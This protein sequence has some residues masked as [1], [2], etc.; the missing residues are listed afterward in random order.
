MWVSTL[1]GMTILESVQVRLVRRRVLDC[2]YP[3]VFDLFLL[4]ESKQK[5][6]W[7]IESPQDSGARDFK[8]KF[9][10]QVGCPGPSRVQPVLN[11]EALRF[12]TRVRARG[13]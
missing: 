6:A 9:L 4:L 11:A 3:C 12:A 10:A 13:T 2:E 1:E 8:R 7:F 5:R